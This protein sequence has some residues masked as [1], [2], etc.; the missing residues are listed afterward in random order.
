MIRTL[1]F[2]LQLL[3]TINEHSTKIYYEPKCRMCIR[4]VSAIASQFQEEHTDHS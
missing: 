2:G 1:C 3:L 4:L